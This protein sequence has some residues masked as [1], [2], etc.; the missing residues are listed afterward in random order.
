MIAI[1][2]L[3][4]KIDQE[5]RSIHQEMALAK[6]SGKTTIASDENLLSEYLRLTT[7]DGIIPAIQYITLNNLS[8]YFNLYQDDRERSQ[9]LA[10][11]AE[12]LGLSSDSEILVSVQV[13]QH[14]YPL[15]YE[16]SQEQLLLT[17]ERA[18]SKMTGLKISPLQPTRTKVEPALESQIILQPLPIAKESP[19]KLMIGI[20]IGI[21]AVTFSVV[22]SNSFNKQVTVI[23]ARGNDSSVIRKTPQQNRPSPD[24]FLVDHY[25]ALNRRD[26][27]STWDNLSENFKRES[28]QSS[29]LA[30]AE[31][32]KW[33]NSVRS[34]DLQQSETASISSDGSRATV[35]YRFGFTMNTGRFIQDKHNLMFL[36]WSQK[37]DKWLIDKR[38]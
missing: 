28:G 36:V 1:D 21:A 15:I 11:T 7:T 22:L 33:W 23:P 29:A 13:L 8:R 2:A 38:I 18:I 20:G 17:Q 31:Y 26:Y 5:L 3:I 25:Q 14:T 16:I 4:N 35:N 24:Q 10:A 37:K 27:D 32:E 6:N 34:V 12:E 19:S 30:R 9:I